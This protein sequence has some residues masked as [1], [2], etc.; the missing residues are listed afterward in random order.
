MAVDVSDRLG[1]A[2]LA[3][4]FVV[5]KGFVKKKA[6]GNAGA[7][8]GGVLGGV[9]SAAGGA[10]AAKTAP[11][12][13]TPAFKGLAYLAVTEDEV[14]LFKAKQGFKS[15]SV[16]EEIGRLARGEIESSEYRGGYLSHLTIRPR[17]DGPWEFDVQRA[18][19]KSG[20]AVADALGATIS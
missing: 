17:E 20:R 2:Q 16:S 15:P 19:K 6:L 18:Y 13:D 9:I 5:G 14:V 3:G 8:V 11:R 4:A 7:G 10:V 12:S 1:K